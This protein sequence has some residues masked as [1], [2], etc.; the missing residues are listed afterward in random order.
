M[1]NAGDLRM[2][3]SCKFELHLY[4]LFYARNKPLSGNCY[5]HVF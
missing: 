2:D 1:Q 5:S 4:T 3:Y